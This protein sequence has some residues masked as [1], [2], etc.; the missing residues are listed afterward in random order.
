MKN[1]NYLIISFLL[2]FNVAFSTNIVNI[3]KNR[4][5]LEADEIIIYK[6]KDEIKLNGNVVVNSGDVNLY[7][8]KMTVYFQEKKGKN[9]ITKIIGSGNIL[10]K[11]ENINANSDNFSY[12]PSKSIITM[13]N[14]VTL[15][16]RDSTVY[17]DKL[18]YNTIT[19]NVTINSKKERVKIFINDIDS[20]KDRYGK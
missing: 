18:I 19:G 1:K 2:I 9:D 13:Y 12:E 20:F 8:D 7:A 5:K 14:N 6:N 4:T 11:N 17:S 15:K 3:D 16:E 10:L